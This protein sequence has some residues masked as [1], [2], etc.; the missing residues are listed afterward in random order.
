MY[1][2]EDD[3]YYGGIVPRNP[4]KAAAITNGTHFVNK[5]E[6]KLLRKLKQKTGMTEAE[7]RLDPTHRKELSKA[8]DKGEQS[9]VSRKEKTEKKIMKK[10]TKQLG[11]AKEHP[12]CVEMYK[13]LMD[14][15]RK[16]NPYYRF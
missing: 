14:A 16:R 5:N 8:Q 6:G 12:K 4:R 2:D 9:T 1:W 3:E 15:Y 13:E 10:V 7:L 11:L